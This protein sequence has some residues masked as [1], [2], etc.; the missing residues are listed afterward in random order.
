[1]T[2]GA[3]IR[4]EKLAV[5][6]DIKDHRA[7]DIFTRKLKWAHPMPVRERMNYQSIINAH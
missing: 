1:M 5:L 6:V 3:D 7:L 4:V 2:Q